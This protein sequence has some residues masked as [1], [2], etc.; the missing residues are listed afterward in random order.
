M[1]NKKMKCKM[2]EE[3]DDME[4]EMCPSCSRKDNNKKNS[5]K[6]FMEG[7]G[8]MI[9]GDTGSKL[10]AGEQGPPAPKNWGQ[11][12]NTIANEGVDVGKGIKLGGS[13]A[14]QA[15][16]SAMTQAKPKIASGPPASIGGSSS[17]LGGTA[18]QKI[19]LGANQ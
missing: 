16:S 6:G 7:L 10:G 2:E 18:R 19:K 5:P 11:Q 13:K 15:A 14:G 9:T 3:D 8:S 17:M 1:K 4:E 12:Y